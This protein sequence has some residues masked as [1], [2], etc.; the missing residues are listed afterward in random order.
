[1]KRFPFLRFFT[2]SI[3]GLSAVSA[4]SDHSFTSLPVPTDNGNET[5]VSGPP[6]G[7]DVLVTVDPTTTFQTLEGFGAAVGWFHQSILQHPKREEIF[8]LIFKDLGLD[9]LRFRNRYDHIDEEVDLDNEA[10]ILAAAVERADT[11]LSIMLSS[12]SPPANLKQSGAE[13]CSG[14][15][16]CTLIRTG[17]SYDYEGFADWWYESIAAYTA[18]GVTPD[19][20]SIQNEPDF[21][22]SGWEGCRFDPSETGAYP[23]YDAALAAVAAAV[24][25]MDA[26]PKI[27]GPEV[28]GIHWY[29]P[30]EYLAEIDFDLIY[31]V[32]HHLYEM[33]FDDIWDWRDPGPDS[34]IDEMTAVNALAED[35]P[36]FQTEFQTDE[37]N[38]IEG[39]F[40]TAWLIHNSL[41]QEQVAAFLY[42]D[43]ARPNMGLV[44]LLNNNT[45]YRVRDQ[46]YAMM[47][48]ARFTDAGDLRV[49]AVSDEET[50]RVTAFS[51]TD[52]NRITIVLLNVGDTAKTVGV[53]AKGI[54]PATTE[55]YRTAY[56]PG[57]TVAWEPLTEVSDRIVSMPGRS[58]V[59]V[60]IT[61]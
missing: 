50:I 14:N 15:T 27:L 40:E 30:H 43:L 42:W 38:D 8:D 56:D 49:D 60:V 41:A 2:L 19:Y 48:Y 13:D 12:W 54:A 16:D 46:Y 33:G 36:I 39:G 10:D 35:K 3:V 34:F 20:I 22:P 1:M 18:V 24:A 47:H 55:Y 51:K 61:Y 59:T 23:G 25:D 4:C 31:G 26:P 9:I 52:G 28:L 57:N 6:E 11:P 53:Y 5:D 44:S 21:I 32:A 7:A 37:D 45:D 29:K 58:Q 17:D